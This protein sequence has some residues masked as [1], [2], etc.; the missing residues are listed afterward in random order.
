MKDMYSKAQNKVI[1]MILKTM[2]ENLI[3]R[4]NEQDFAKWVDMKQTI[5]RFQDE[6]IFNN[7]MY[8]PLKKG[9]GLTLQKEN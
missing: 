2:R 3:T 7:I 6:R 5:Q 4:F 1:G 9:F 8:N